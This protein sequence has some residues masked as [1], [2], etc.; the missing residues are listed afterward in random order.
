MSE[1]LEGK[2]NLKCSIDLLR[3]ALIKVMPEWEA[4]IRIDPLGNL[5]AV[6][7]N[8][9]V[10]KDKTFNL[11]VPGPNNVYNCPAAPGNSF[12]DIGMMQEKDGTW[13]IYAD[14]SGLYDIKNLEEEIK[15]EI[16]RMRARAYARLRPG[17]EII[18]EINNDVEIATYL[19]IDK[20]LAH[21]VFNT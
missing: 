11:I 19:S 20:N 12:A 2:L 13:T 4:H 7:F 6:N 10:V 18:K 14:R 1:F 3:R 8:G 17:A 15:G 16:L 9:K 5:E 21:E